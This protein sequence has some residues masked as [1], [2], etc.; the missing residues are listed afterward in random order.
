MLANPTDDRQQDLLTEFER[1]RVRPFA[2]WPQLKEQ[3]VWIV[4]GP[5]RAIFI[6]AKEEKA[7]RGTGPGR[8][9][10]VDI[11]GPGLHQGY[12]NGQIAA[13]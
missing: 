9:K 5:M 12:G 3:A 4:D 7:R 6:P 1:S 13:T 10:G 8:E 11:T 2:H